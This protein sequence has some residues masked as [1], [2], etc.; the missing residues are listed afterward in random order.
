MHVNENIVDVNYTVFIKVK[1][2][3][4]VEQLQ[5]THQMRYL[6]CLNWSIIKGVFLKNARVINSLIIVTTKNDNTHAGR[7]RVLKYWVMSF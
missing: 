6:F 2:T 1:E 5:E 3:G 4:K 7:V